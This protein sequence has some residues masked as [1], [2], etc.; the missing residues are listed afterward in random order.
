MVGSRDY[1]DEAIDGNVNVALR[2]RQP[3]SSFKPIVYA[4]A[5][6]KGFT[7]DTLLYDVVTTFKAQPKDYTP[8]NYDDKEHG[9]LS[10]R[11]AL[12]GSLNIPAV[13]T[14]YLTGIDR[15]LDLAEKLGYTTLKDRSRFGLSIVLGGGEVKLLEHVGAF[16]AL[17]GSGKRLN[18]T[19]LLRIEDSS[20]RPLEAWQARRPEQVI[21]EGIA[22]EVTSIL[23]DNAARTFIFGPQSPLILSDRPVAAKT[24]TTN[25]WHDGWT[26]GYT[27]SLAAGVWVGN[28]NNKEMKRGADGVLVAA[29]I[30]NAFMS[31]ALRNTPVEQFPAPE[32]RPVANPILRG[33]GLGQIRARIDRASGK[34]ATALTP[35][36]LVGERTYSAP[37][38]ILY[39]INKDNLDAPPP[40]NPVEDPNFENWEAAVR[41]WAERNTVN[42][43]SAPTTYDDLHTEANRPNIS[44][45]RPSGSGATIAG[46]NLDVEVQGSA[47]RG[48][49]RVE[50]ILDGIVKT[51]LQSAPYT[52]TL[53]LN[54]VP[55]GE[56][57]VVARAYDDI[58]NRGET[59]LRFQV[60]K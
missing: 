18:Q 57:I 1:F 36:E 32:A 19:V 14:I 12:A 29:P 6:E 39:Y 48:I 45:I 37:H 2:P 25:D 31:R 23:S 33:Q 58:L 50:I 40:A 15:V 20:G 30:W 26:I 43:E 3:G 34:L 27:P 52:T 4:A 41:Q 44:F 47:P 60:V 7:P 49:A 22:N 28:N 59:S 55:A 5:F 8:H 56:H 42:M 51:T 24:G 38:S 17:A 54:D 35:A 9:P 10:M 11:G 53:S 46:N 21:P 13:K 16:A